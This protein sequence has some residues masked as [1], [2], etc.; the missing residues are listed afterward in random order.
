MTF[1]KSISTCFSKYAEFKGRASLPEYWWFVL[2]TTLM[3]WGTLLVGQVAMGDN[4]GVA[5]NAIFQLAVFL[6]SMAVLTR[7]L[8]DTNRSGW[9]FLWC[10]TIIGLIP[11]LIW[12]VRKGDQS[13][14]KYGSLS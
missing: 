1:G 13:E 4:G 3:G 8:H 9:N 6:P 7:R 12:L 14:N 5:I 11:V 2:F 10:F